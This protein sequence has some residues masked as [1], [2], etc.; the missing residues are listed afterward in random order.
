MA[1]SDVS[2][3]AIA[4]ICSMAT[5]HI[6]GDLG[7]E[8]R[9]RTGIG[10][11]VTA[12]GGVDAVRR[13]QSGA[14]CDFVVLTQAAIRELAAGGHVSAHSV[15]NLARSV[16]A[17]AV[18]AH[19]PVPDTSDGAA[20]RRAVLAARRV[21]YSSG[22][23]GTHLMRLFQRW[24]IADRMAAKSAQA[25]PG[26]PVA[27][28]IAQGEVDLGFQQLS[29]LMDMP[30][31]RI[32]GTLPDEIQSITMFT[33]A[34]CSRAARRGEAERFLAFA[35]SPDASDVKRR[36]GMEPIET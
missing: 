17:I 34:L 6:L 30:G 7:A 28:L 27:Q 15:T 10:V 26:V 21:G 20:I 5:R 13:I 22:P 33:G 8:H 14:T 36:H 1:A 24:D 16:V 4:G 25:P 3:P 31:I 32:A 23:S 29:E 12:V 18:A 9:R 2:A 11:A 35:A 19:A